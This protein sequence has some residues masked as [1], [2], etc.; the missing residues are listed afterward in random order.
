MQTQSIEHGEVVFEYRAQQ[1][2]SKPYIFTSDPGH[3]WLRVTN[4][5]LK[6]LGIAGQISHYSYT[7]GRYA[8]LE[9][10]C[11]LELFMKAKGWKGNGDFERFVTQR[12]VTDSV[13]R[14]YDSYKVRRASS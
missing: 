3:G 13:I 7:N 14:S 5:E 9:E 10:D 8:Y 2:T 1:Q 11:D 4:A 12:S 6:A